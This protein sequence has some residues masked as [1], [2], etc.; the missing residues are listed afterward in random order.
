MSHFNLQ[1]N[2]CRP[3]TILSYKEFTNFEQ[4]IVSQRM[5]Q[6]DCEWGWFCTAEDEHN[7][8][9]I[10][11]V[12]IM[13]YTHKKGSHPIVASKPMHIPYEYVAPIMFDH[14]QV[15]KEDDQ[16]KDIVSKKLFYYLSHCALFSVIVIISTYA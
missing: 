5:Q 12:P 2:S 6:D 4:A 10:Y 7:P 16:I 1:T 13:N 9:A 11:P 3:H 8:N 14:E 15:E